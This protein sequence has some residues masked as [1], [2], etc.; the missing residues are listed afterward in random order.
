MVRPVGPPR[1]ARQQCAFDCGHRLADHDDTRAVDAVN[2]GRPMNLFF[3]RVEMVAYGET[4]QREWWL[5]WWRG[6]WS[7]GPKGNQ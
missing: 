2:K 4:P 6:Y 1:T 3:T 5:W 7:K